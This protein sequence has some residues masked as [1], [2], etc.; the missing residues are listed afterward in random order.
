MRYIFMLFKVAV[1]IFLLV[2]AL[3][4]SSPV[5]FQLFVGMQWEVPLI[6]LL[7]IF[8]VLGIL[9]GIL[10]VLPYYFK[11]RQEAHFMKKALN[12]PVVNQPKTV[13]DPSDA[14]AN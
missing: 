10:A 7:L 14:V 5:N 4:N 13:H 9:L 1:F 8:L 2:L 12:V 6:V 3:Q 11:V